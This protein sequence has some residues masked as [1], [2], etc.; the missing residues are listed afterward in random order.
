[1]GN[2]WMRSLSDRNMPPQDVEPTFDA[3]HGFD[4]RVRK[5]RGEE[6]RNYFSK[7][8]NYFFPRYF[9]LNFFSSV[10]KGT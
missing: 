8:P 3:H 6:M 2:A 9:L 7:V 4:G 5:E 1:M 10:Q